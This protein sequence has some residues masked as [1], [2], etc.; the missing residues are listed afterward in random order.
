MWRPAKAI[1]PARPRKPDPKASRATPANGFRPAIFAKPAKSRIR[2][3]TPEID[4][5]IHQIRL[6]R[7]LPWLRAGPAAAYQPTLR[8]ISALC[9]EFSNLSQAPLQIVQPAQPSARAAFHP[10]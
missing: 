3:S 5:R 6:I 1:T 2:P 8:L 7:N 10:T 4:G 9:G